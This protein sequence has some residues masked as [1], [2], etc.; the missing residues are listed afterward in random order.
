VHFIRRLAQRVLHISAG[1]LTP[2]AGGYDY[3]LD[4]TKAVSEKEALVA[5]E[6]LH[7]FQPAQAEQNT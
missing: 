2:Y 3:Y 1:Q 4:R 5:G 6:Q 7:D